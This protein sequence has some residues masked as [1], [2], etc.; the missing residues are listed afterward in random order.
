MYLF[1]M[2]TSSFQECLLN[3]FPPLLTGLFVHLVFNFLS[4]LY[5][6]DFNPHSNEYL[7][8]MLTH[9]MGYVFAMVITSFAVH[10]SQYPSPMNG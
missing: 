8:N 5:I 1:E 2:C 3:V 4:S 10:N 9:S 6:L 7:A